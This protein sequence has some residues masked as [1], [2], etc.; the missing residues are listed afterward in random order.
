[1]YDYRPGPLVSGEEGPE[2]QKKVWDELT[3]KLE[4]IQPG[5]MANV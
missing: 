5:I 2:I 4:K 1:M 3:T